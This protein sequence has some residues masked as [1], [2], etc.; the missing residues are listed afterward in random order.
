MVYSKD[1]QEDGNL[2][3]QKDG[4]LCKADKFNMV[5]V[6]SEADE[7]IMVLVDSE[8]IREDEKL[9]RSQLVNDL[10]LNTVKAEL[11]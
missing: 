6:Y 2:C 7:F 11:V 3:I 4:N 9:N 8:V 1:I 10:I 5:V